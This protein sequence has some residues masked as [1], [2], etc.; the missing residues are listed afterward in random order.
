VAETQPVLWMR[1]LDRLAGP[2]CPRMVV[3]DPRRTA[4]AVEADVHLQVEPGCNVAL[5]NGIL[6]E[7]IVNDR[8]DGGWVER[9]TVGFEEL[10][11]GVMT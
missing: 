4:P 3:I 10:R 5:L 2:D 8:S 7:L 6:R 11:K 1:M 9:H